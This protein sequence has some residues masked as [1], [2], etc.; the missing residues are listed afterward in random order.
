MDCCCRAIIIKDVCEVTV[1]DSCLL[2]TCKCTMYM[3]TAAVPP[4]TV[5]YQGLYW[6]QVDLAAGEQRMYD[7]T[8]GLLMRLCWAASSKIV[9]L[10]AWVWQVCI[11]LLLYKSGSEPWS[12]QLMDNCVLLRHI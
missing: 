1:A 10:A 6:P 12:W 5:Q 3:I 2:Q 7:I 9:A 11:L 4:S 8:A